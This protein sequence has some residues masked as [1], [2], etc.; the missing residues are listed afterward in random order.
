MVKE[1]P[2]LLKLRN[3]LEMNLYCGKAVDQN[4]DAAKVI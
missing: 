2:K 1:K 4:S 3:L